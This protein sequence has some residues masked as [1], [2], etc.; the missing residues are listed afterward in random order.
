MKGPDRTAAWVKIAK[1]SKSVVSSTSMKVTVTWSGGDSRLQVLTSGLR[2]YQMQKRR[3]GGE[4]YTY[5]PDDVDDPQPRLGARRRPTSSASAPATR[6]ATG[7][8]GSTTTVTT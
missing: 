1:V 4:W 5:E 7:A 2:Y 6:P 8:P 3:V